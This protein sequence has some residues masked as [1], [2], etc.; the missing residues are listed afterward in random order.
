MRP[1][2][3]LLVREEVKD[4]PEG[5]ATRS[6]VTASYL[7]DFVF[8]DKQAWREDA[9]L[10]TVDK[11]MNITGVFHLSSGS[12]DATTIDKKIVANLAIQSGANG[13]IL[14][15]N[16]PSG[17]PRPSK[18]D[19]HYTDEI[20][21]T[22]NVFGTHLIDHIVLGEKTFFSFDEEKELKYAQKNA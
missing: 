9:Y 3:L 10:L 12:M 13:V 20:K 22:L 16:H 1:Y 11:A 15:H 14:A 4:Y 5:K 18:N 6:N 19:I 21:R 8:N 7:K 2:K 17:D